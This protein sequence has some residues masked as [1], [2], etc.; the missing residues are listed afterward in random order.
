MSIQRPKFIG[1]FFFLC[2]S[3]AWYVYGCVYACV[4]VECICV[5]VNVH[6]GVG[7]WGWH[8]SSSLILLVNWDSDCH[9]T[10]GPT[11]YAS[12][13]S[14][15]ALESPV[16]ISECWDGRP[17]AF[18]D[19]HSLGAGGPSLSPTLTQQVVYLLSH[20]LSPRSLVVLVA[21]IVAK[22]KTFCYAAISVHTQ[23]FMF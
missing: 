20:V 8:M 11:L 16:F 1:V 21:I 13:F 9:S 10:S 19:W 18:P 5:G 14:Q 4:H 7:A 2:L 6:L 22:S 3:C 12:L 15:L 17:A 23:F